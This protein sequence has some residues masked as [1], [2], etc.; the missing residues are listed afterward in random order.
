MFFMQWR[1][2]F[3]VIKILLTFFTV[4]ILV[5]GTFQ[6]IISYSSY[7]DD[8][9]YDYVSR[10]YKKCEFSKDKYDYDT[11]VNFIVVVVST[12]ISALIWV[13]S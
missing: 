8:D 13:S 4:T 3:S 2:V 12:G 10:K 11:D 9:D 1:M 5:A 7:C 6:G